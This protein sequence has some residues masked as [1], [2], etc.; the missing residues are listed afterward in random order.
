[1]TDNITNQAA[2]A[3]GCFRNCFRLDLLSIGALGFL[4]MHSCPILMLVSNTIYIVVSWFS[5]IV[6]GTN[7][8]VITLPLKT[9]SELFRVNAQY[10]H[11]PDDDDDDVDGDEVDDED[12]ENEDEE[13]ANDDDVDVKNS[14]ERAA[15]LENCFLGILD[16]LSKKVSNCYRSF[17]M[18]LIMFFIFT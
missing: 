16:T 1:M 12:E 5:N 4:F 11:D 8:P 13:D 18:Y 14:N 10:H 9:I 17:P 3:V 7:N 2:N 15:C 6:C